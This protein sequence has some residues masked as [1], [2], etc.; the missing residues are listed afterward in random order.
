MIPFTNQQCATIDASATDVRS[1]NDTQP[2]LRI[3]ESVR[4]TKRSFMNCP[5]QATEQANPYDR[6][7]ENQRA[8]GISLDCAI[9]ATVEAY[10][11]GKPATRGK[12]KLGRSERDSGF[13]SSEFVHSI[14]LSAWDSEEL[15][16]ALSRYLGQERFSNPILLQQIAAACPQ[17]VQRAVRYSGLVLQQHS[18][19][20][21]ELN[22]VAVSNPDIAELC[23][24][25]DI[26]DQALRERVATV[27]MWKDPLAELLNWN[28][29]EEMDPGIG[30]VDLICAR[31]QVVLVLEV[32][33]TF[34]R[35][36]QRDAWLHKSTTLRKAGGQLRRKVPAVRRALA[37]GSD[38]ARVL[39]LEGGTS[40]L[41][42]HGW[43]VDTSI[44]W[45]HQ[46]FGGFLKVSLE[47]VL[48]ALRDDRHLLNDPDG[49]FSGR[50]AEM[51]FSVPDDT[52]RQATLY[53]TGFSA[54]D[55]VDVIE[56][57]LV[58]EAYDRS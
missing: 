31:D 18:P 6:L 48:I 46:Q 17:V 57:Q 20:R 19:R 1:R 27:E 12:R 44:E 16:L 55:F 23:R 41:S 47:E 33:S 56:K 29:S 11:D 35:K 53:P 45:D 42:I 4:A 24:V 8:S 5:S 13:W 28:P 43:I 49:I 37:E 30:E 25:L 52:Q 38:L 3:P 50:Y 15:T 26:F 2:C 58:W 10:L 40:F 32:K 34:I 54:Q 51:D 9:E 14:P 21:A 39:D 22:R 7:F 36:S